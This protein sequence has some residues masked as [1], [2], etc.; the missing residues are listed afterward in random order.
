MTDSFVPLL[1]A[2]DCP[3]CVYL[4]VRSRVLGR[5]LHVWPTVLCAFVGNFQFSTIIFT[6]EWNILPLY[7]TIIKT[8]SFVSS[9]VSEILSFVILSAVVNSIFF[10]GSIFVSEFYSMLFYFCL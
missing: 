4:S 2:S 9:C 7:L 10:R 6:F 1:S 3:V 8:F 5:Y